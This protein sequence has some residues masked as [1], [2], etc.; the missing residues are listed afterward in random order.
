MFLAFKQRGAQL[1]RRYAF[2]L[3]RKC[4][5]N[6]SF[7][8]IHTLHAEAQEAQQYPPPPKESKKHRRT[9]CQRFPAHT[10]ARARPVLPGLGGACHL[11]GQRCKSACKNTQHGVLQS[12]DPC[13]P[14]Q[15]SIYPSIL[16]DEAVMPDM[17]TICL[18]HGR[19][20]T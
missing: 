9:A 11:Q 4:S 15:I 8:H 2:V 19:R 13:I 5:V 10:E 20:R 1:S 12:S 7:A 16:I 14:S 17:H 6:S 18:R 3:W